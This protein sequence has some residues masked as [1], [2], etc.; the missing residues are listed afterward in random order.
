MNRLIDFF[1][2]EQRLRW[3]VYLTSSGIAFAYALVNLGLSNKTEER[4]GLETVILLCLLITIS[5]AV[6]IA[7]G[8]LV[9]SEAQKPLLTWNLSLRLGL[10]STVVL[11]LIAQ[12]NIPKMQAAIVDFRLRSLATWLDT[13]QA[14]NLSDYQ[15]R[16]QY[17]KI[18]SIVNTSSTNQMPVNPNLLQKAQTALSRSLKQ[19]S[20]TDQTRELGWA[21]AIDL[22]SLSYTRNVQTGAIIPRQITTTPS[23]VFNTPVV[24]TTGHLYMQGEHSLI[25]LGEGGG[26]FVAFQST[27]VFD[28]IDFRSVTYQQPIVIGDDRSTAFVR[29][30]TLEGVIQELERITWVDVRFENSRVL[31][32]EGT[33][34]RLRNVSFKDCD[35]SH[36]GIPPGPVSYELERRIRDAKGQPITFAYEP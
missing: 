25:F 5:V 19:P 18:E 15:I 33:P 21:T 22:E 31:Y 9:L 28:K 7:K 1:L 10:A 2:T 11:V 24:I 26:Q 3:K 34:L 27:I 32:A 30:S 17:Q 35:L 20:L 6:Y 13:V 4:V 8:K 14:A 23:A 16:S 36:L 12:I 29:D